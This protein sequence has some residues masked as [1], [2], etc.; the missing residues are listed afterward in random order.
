MGKGRISRILS[1]ILIVTSSLTLLTEADMDF[2]FSYFNQ[3]NQ[4]DIATIGDANVL[5]NNL[6]LTK[7]TVTGHG[8]LDFSVGW[9]LYKNPMT[10]WS[11]RYKQ[12]ITKFQQSFN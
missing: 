10:L 6:F 11:K 7:S 12:H 2:G 9:A 3:S 4:D 1:S 5:E 8:N